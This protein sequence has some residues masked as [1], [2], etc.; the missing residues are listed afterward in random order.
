MA[1]RCIAPII[2]QKNN[3]QKPFSE[4]EDKERGLCKERYDICMRTEKEYVYR[5]RMLCSV[6]YF[7]CLKKATR[8]E[9]DKRN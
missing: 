3:Y 6:P 5:N 7:Q 2:V 4:E 9:S 1:F 8:T